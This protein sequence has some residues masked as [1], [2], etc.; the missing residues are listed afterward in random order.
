MLL[1]SGCRDIIQTTIRDVQRQ[2]A[3]GP[4]GIIAYL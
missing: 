4:I 1:F 3:D 2:M